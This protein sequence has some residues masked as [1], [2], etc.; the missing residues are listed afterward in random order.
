MSVLSGFSI[1]FTGSISGK[2]AIKMSFKITPHEKRV[3]TVAT[4]PCEMLKLSFGRLQ[5]Q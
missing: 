5:Q 4:L 1:F 3:A 2:F